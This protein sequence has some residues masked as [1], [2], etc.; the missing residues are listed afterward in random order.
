MTSRRKY[1]VLPALDLPAELVAAWTRLTSANPELAS[2][3]FAPEYTMTVAQVVPGV[4]VG[5]VEE[6]GEPVAFLP[7]ERT[8]LGLGKRLRLCDYQGLIAASGTDLDAREL[9]RGCGLRSW[10]FDHLAATQACFRPFHT[11]V[12]DS[13]V[14]DL[15]RGFEGFLADR[16]AAGRTELIKRCGTKS[17]KLEREIGPLR[18]EMHVED[19]AVLGTLLEW[20]AARHESRHSRELLLGILSRLCR[21]QAECLRGTLTV[22]YA[23]SAIAAIHCGLRSRTT[24]HW[25]FPTYNPQ[26]DKYSP[27]MI[28]LLRMAEAAAPAGVAMID[29]GRG[30]QDY[31][32]QLMNRSISVAEGAVIASPVVAA[33]RA[34]KGLVRRVLRRDRAAPAAVAP[35]PVAE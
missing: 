6:E 28:M 20:K 21:V 35:A 33:L 2:P 34:G 29:L 5:I 10:D 22:L 32:R 15:P 31:K 11:R 30:N 7:F 25:W 8:A 17:R 16:Q 24:W 19:P 4:Q 9:I 13:P 1:R 3:F 27:G 26:F 18:L 14:I 23:G 12:V